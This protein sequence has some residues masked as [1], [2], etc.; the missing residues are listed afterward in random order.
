MVNDSQ[1]R[2]DVVFTINGVCPLH[3]VT[4]EVRNSLDVDRSD[5]VLRKN[6]GAQAKVPSTSERVRVGPARE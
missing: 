6:R 1:E 4:V 3:A 2:H 5:A